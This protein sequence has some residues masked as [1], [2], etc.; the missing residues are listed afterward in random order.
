[1]VLLES[2]LQTT[3]EK[4]ASDLHIVP[5]YYPTIRINSELYPL[6]LTEVLDGSAT[7]TILLAILTEKQKEELATNKE[8]DFSYEVAGNHRFRINYYMAKGKLGGAFRL[9]PPVIKTIEQLGLP[10][11]FHTFTKVRQGLILFTGPTGE[12]KS[13]SLASIINEINLSTSKNIITIEDPIE[14][15]YPIGKSIISQREVHNDTLSMPIALR[16][17]LREDPDVVL[18]G[19]MRDYD[20]IQT[21]LTIA[22]TGHLVF[23]TLHTNSA[24]DTINRIVDVFPS[25]QQNQIR[26]QL[27]AVLYSIV[28]QRLL[29]NIDKTGRVA[30][31]EI[32]INT[33]AVSANI[34]DGKAFMI[35]NILETQ[36]VDGMKI[37]EK[38]LAKL[39]HTGQIS[40]DTAIGASIRQKE[41]MKFIT[42]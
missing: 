5:G 6:L 27:S 14:F 4:D 26:N 19:E 2:L 30:A 11:I 42:Q 38:S 9:I 24:P 1:M 29:P 39:Y 37:M 36:E 13:T 40:R 22:E 23:S 18:V 10:E 41:I 15:V 17:I 20:T 32:L 35:D 12:G 8:I 31:T 16:S 21:A 25:H 3:I 28:A 34:R 7:N 33:P